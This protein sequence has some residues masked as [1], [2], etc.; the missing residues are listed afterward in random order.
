MELPQIVIDTNVIISAQRSQRG[1]S[2]R[3]LSLIDTG[4]FDIHISIPLALEYEEV[5]LRQRLSL[6]LT[7][8]DV[9]DMVDALCALAQRHKKIYFRWR[10][11]LRDTSDEF[12]LELA[13]IAKCDYIISYNKKDF[14]GAEKFG[15]QVLDAREFLREIGDLP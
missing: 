2:S 3:L 6:G 15:I 4:R 13:V 10:P 9:M 7:N 5:L 14:I 8:D 11:Q 1:A 12:I